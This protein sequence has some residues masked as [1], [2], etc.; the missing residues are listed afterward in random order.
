MKTVSVPKTVTPFLRRNPVN[1]GQLF[2]VSA[3]SVNQVFTVDFEV[4]PLYVEADYS[5]NLNVQPVEIVY[6]EVSA[7][8]SVILRLC[9]GGQWV[10]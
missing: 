5:L 4:N 10:D 9:L 7:G 2:S 8:L 1:T 6:D 3:P